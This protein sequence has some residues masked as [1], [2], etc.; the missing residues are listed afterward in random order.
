M[1]KEAPAAATQPSPE[2][3]N[4][5]VL[6]EPLVRGNTTITEVELRK[7]MT[8]ELRGIS[9]SELINLDVNA[10]R[11]VLPRITSPALTDAEIGRLDPADLLDIGGKVA[12]F[13]LKKSVKEQ[14]FLTA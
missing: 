9:L 5:V 13:L 1:S 3:D 10:L 4:V 14:A 11:K 8:G 6:D 2:R 12:T 7:P